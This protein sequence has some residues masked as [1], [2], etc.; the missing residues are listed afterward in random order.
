M[1]NEEVEELLVKDDQEP[2]EQIAVNNQIQILEVTPDISINALAG[3]FHPSTL[4][5]MGRYGKKQVKILIDNGSNHNF[6]KPDVADKL[7]LKRTPITKFKVWTGSGAYLTCRSKCERVPLFIQG[8]E[9]VVDLFVL[10]IKG[11]EIVL[12]VQWLIEL[13]T[14]KTNYQELIMEFQWRGKEVKL[15]GE[16]LLIGTPCKGRKLSKLAAYEG[17]S[18]FYQLN[19][20]V[21]QSNELKEI[22][23]NV[24][25]AVQ[26]VL[27][28]YEGVFQEPKELP[29]RR[30]ID[31]QIPLESNAQPVNVRPTSTHTTKRTRWR[32]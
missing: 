32:D 22:D 28:Q 25:T 2:E 16:N 11:S 26:E 31:H 12:G 9:F 15:M 23:A 6:I 29:L 5:V 8:H 18:E 4:R 27:H 3:H 30:V 24:P 13:G 17:V 20:V 1:G 14:I 19:S 21:S 7:S 10:E